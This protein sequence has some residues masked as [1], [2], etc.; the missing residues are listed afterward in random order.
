RPLPALHLMLEGEPDKGSAPPGAGYFG[1]SEDGDSAVLDA[2]AQVEMETVRSRRLGP[3]TVTMADFLWDNVDRFTA[4][5]PARGAPARELRVLPFNTA[6]PSCRPQ[7]ASAL[8]AASQW[9]QTVM[10]AETAA[11]YITAEELDDEDR[12]PSEELEDEPPA[13]RVA[14]LEVLPAPAAEDPF[15]ESQVTDPLHQ[16]LAAQMEQTRMLMDRLAPSRPSDAVAAALGSGQGSG[17]GESS[18]VRGC[19]ARDAFVRQV[20][21]LERVAEVAKG[22]ALRELGLERAEPNLMKLY[23]E[24]RLPLSSFAEPPPAMWLNT[25]RSGVKPFSA[26]A[27][28]S[29]IAGNIAYLRDLD[30]LETRMN[31]LSKEKAGKTEEATDPEAAANPKGKFRRRPKAKALADGNA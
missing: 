27:H 9:I 11:E 21:D 3:L 15:A 29:W 25:R 10:D 26:L 7:A 6:T 12:G 17:S 1:A 20:Q 2:E 30:F 18:G 19:M 8:S 4:A 31:N 13:A 14:E 28:P 22:N 23:V 24:R 5:H 16:I